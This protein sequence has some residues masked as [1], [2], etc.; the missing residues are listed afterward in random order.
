MEENTVYHYTSLETL[1]KIIN[2][3]NVEKYELYLRA[4]H[5]DFLNDFTEHKIAVSLLRDKLIEYDN[6]LGDN[7]KNFQNLLNDKRM[8]FFKWE[9]IDDLFPFI[10][11]FS[12]N[13]DNLPMWNTYGNKSEGVALG[14]DKTKL[15]QLNSCRFAKCIYDTKDYEEHLES[16]IR[17][18]HNCIK[19]SNYGID[20][21]RE[22]D[23]NPLKEYFKILP[24]LKDTNYNYEH[25]HRL[26]VQ[27]KRQDREHIKFQHSNNLLKPYLEIPIPF[28]CLTEI[29]LGPTLSIDKLKMSL[30]ILLRQKNKFASLDKEDGKIHLRKSNIP[31]RHI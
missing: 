13:W 10:I 17:D 3:V 5:I 27:L 11:S 20:F 18:I 21:E 30:G 29:V 7:S 9:E 28:D 24:I 15:E 31:F 8:S 12:E 16:I 26:I 14:F 6:S 19:V 25:E 1:G 22:F 2:G 23:S 4:T